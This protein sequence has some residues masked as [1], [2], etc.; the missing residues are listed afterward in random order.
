MIYKRAAAIIINEE[1]ILLMHRIK[2]GKEKDRIFAR[3]AIE[4][5]NNL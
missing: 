1:K 3:S 2:E 4:V 5:Y